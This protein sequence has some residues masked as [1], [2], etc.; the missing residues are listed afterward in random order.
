MSSLGEAFR[1]VYSLVPRAA[2]IKKILEV[3][4]KTEAQHSPSAYS[5]PE[6]FIH[7]PP[8][9][10]P[11][12][13][14]PPRRAIPSEAATSAAPTN[15]S[16]TSRSQQPANIAITISRSNETPKYANELSTTLTYQ[17]PGCQFYNR[18]KR[19]EV[20]EFSVGDRVSV[21]VPKLDRTA[22]D[23]PRIPAEI[24]AIHG[25][26]VKSHSLTTAFGTISTKFTGGDL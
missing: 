14:P 10:S 17:P 25:P 26:K 7:S 2:F 24:I 18:R 6:E 16:T 21:A 20:Q 19:I 3:K 11:S 8:L 1:P 15:A 5:S 22:T 9:P 23:L 13:P 4:D 12:P